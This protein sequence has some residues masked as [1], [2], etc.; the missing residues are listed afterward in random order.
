MFL[1]VLGSH[2]QHKTSTELRFDLL[3]TRLELTP[4]MASQTLQGQA[5]LWIKPYFYPQK[6]VVLDAKGM[7][8]S[9]VKVKG[10]A[11]T[12]M[13][14][15]KHLI[16]Q[17]E[18]EITARDTLELTI[19]YTA[20]PTLLGAALPETK[21]TDRGLYFVDP[22]G[23][24]PHRPTQL[25]TQGETQSNSCWFPTLDSPNQKHTQEVILHVEDRFETLSNGLLKSRKKL[26]GGKRQDIWVLSQPHSVYLTM[27]AVGEWE[28]VKDT[29]YKGHEIAYYLE[30]EYAPF[31]SQIFG[32]TGAMIQFFEWLTAT[33]FPWP[34]Y[35]QIVARD[36]VTGA[37]ENTGATVHG[38]FILR[39]PGQLIDQ[40]Q[41][42]IIAHELFHQWFGNLIT[43]E[44]WSHLPMNESFA[45]Y[46]EYLWRE[47]TY[48]KEEAEW[49]AHKAWGQ[50]L[51]EAKEKQV[52][53]IRYDYT[54]PDDMFD[55][56][57]Y[58][59]GGRILHLLRHEIGDDAFL[60]SIQQFL[61]RFAFQT[62]EVENFRQIVEEV[63][64]RD[65]R[66]FF[67]Q[68]FFQSGHP[69]LQV[70]TQIADGKSSW[71]VRQVGPQRNYR[72]PLEWAWWDGAQWRYESQRMEGDSLQLALPNAQ[73]DTPLI[74]DPHHILPAEIRH[75]KTTAQLVFDLANAPRFRTR[76]ASLLALTAA[77]DS[78]GFL[79]PL[80]D[81]VIRNQVIQ[82]LKDPFWVVRQAA[83]QALFDY[84]GEGFL[85]V[86]KALQ[87]TIQYDP[88]AMVRAEG[89][90]AMKHF[91]NA[92]NELLF[93][94]ALRD[95]SWLVQGSALEA[96]LAN[97]PQDAK[98]LIEPYV[99]RV[100]VHSWGAIANYYVNQG[101]VQ[102]HPWFL[103]TLPKLSESDLYSVMGLY[104]AY[105]TLL[106]ADEWKLALPLVRKWALESAQPIVRYGAIQLASQLAELVEFQDVIQQARKTETDPRLKALFDHLNP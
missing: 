11:S 78:L 16:I 29:E 64:G 3:H 14:D 75:P 88:H 23:T 97:R 37:M 17:L 70:E 91:L 76:F 32:K 35:A 92:Q 87:H 86:E 25:W 85:A 83:V 40:D 36:F 99:T 43:C 66:W 8:I 106:P 38:D 77:E 72:I 89:I 1:I 84:D 26:P 98:T 2:A 79:A 33:P 69:T 39:T 59:K 67:D 9:Q 65:M 54:D 52:P 45:D 47:A 49:V 31:A 42:D 73:P 93:R 30:K 28:K 101:D 56:H 44:S 15:Q 48:G 22:Q 74:V 62:V 55:S 34:G 12:F 7:L 90:L 80:Q 95:T 63:T 27:I 60:I 41:E 82:S 50:Y 6:E 4:Q 24:D 96:I 71:M 94:E 68:W 51:E 105:L 102:Q 103:T 21:K 61:K 46:A 19:A 58:A 100:D 57:S 13:Y 18:R 81:S 5:T 104:A 20:G 53:L 10:Q